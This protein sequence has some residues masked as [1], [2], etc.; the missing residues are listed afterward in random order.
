MVLRLKKLKLVNKQS[1]RDAVVY[2]MQYRFDKW[3]VPR[4]MQACMWAVGARIKLDELTEM[5]EDIF[6]ESKDNPNVSYD[7]RLNPYVRY[8]CTAY[9]SPKQS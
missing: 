3:W 9:F 7:R 4:H 8:K 6:Q 2:M 1:V 5:M